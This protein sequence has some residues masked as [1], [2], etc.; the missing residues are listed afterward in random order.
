M[1]QNLDARL[2]IEM[3]RSGHVH[4]KLDGKPPKRG[5]VMLPEQK[6]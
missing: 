2:S 6:R 5:W 3:I 4:W 1:P